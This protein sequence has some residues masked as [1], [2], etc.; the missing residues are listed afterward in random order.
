MLK[1]I[2]ISLVATCSISSFSAS[3]SVD[4]NELSAYSKVPV[5]TIQDAISKATYQETI[6]KT[7]TRP[8][9][10]KPW[11]TYRKLFI[12]SDR[13]KKGVQF[14]LNN[15]KILQKA[16]A[17]TG[18]EPEI[19]CAIIGVETFY[20]KNMGTWSVLDA[21][22]TL[23]FNYPPREAYFSKEFANYIKLANAQGWDLKEI[24]GSYAG[25]MGMGQFMP[26]SYLNY[27]IDFNN[28]GHINIFTDVE[29][30][31][32]SVANY[33]KGHGWQ[34]G[35]GILYPAHINANVDDLLKYEWTLKAADLYQ[36]GISTKVNINPNEKVRL[37]AFDLE[38]NKKAYTVAMHNF[39]V[40]TRYNKSPLYAAVIYELSQYIAKEY[41]DY[42]NAHGQIVHNPGRKP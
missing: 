6:I 37:Y 12:T 24:K 28:D 16:Y 14:Y 7:M 26:S 35:R 15:E 17:L 21:L 9:E 42:K 34:K 36:R 41:R 4:L 5:E 23:G 38:N 3:A 10:S 32:G 8:Y 27:A 20:G 22:Y 2:L 39:Y 1:K 29:D 33:F 13:V 31:I 30:A 40:I 25:A 19:V 18:V 11:Y